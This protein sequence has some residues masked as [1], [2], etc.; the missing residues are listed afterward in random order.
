MERGRDGEVWKAGVG[1]EDK[2][3]KEREGRE[4]REEFPCFFYGRP[5]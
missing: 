5:M 4:E 3:G 2:E 1:R